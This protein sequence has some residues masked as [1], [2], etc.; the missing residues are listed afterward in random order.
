[1]A[2]KTSIKY[3][4]SKAANGEARAVKSE[5]KNTPHMLAYFLDLLIV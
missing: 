2:H 4:G 1:M 5:N 3:K